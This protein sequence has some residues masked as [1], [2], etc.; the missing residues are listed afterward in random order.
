[1]LNAIYLNEEERKSLEKQFDF[2]Q[3]E[4]NKYKFEADK[5]Q[6]KNSSKYMKTTEKIKKSTAESEAL[7]KRLI[8]N[9]E[10]NEYLQKEFTLL[11]Q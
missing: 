1:M 11:S 10:N 8:K 3:A 2:K 6:D 5:V 4:I 7:A 9:V